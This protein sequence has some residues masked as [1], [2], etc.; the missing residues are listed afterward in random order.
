MCVAEGVLG[1]AGDRKPTMTDERDISEQEYSRRTA[2]KM[3]GTTGAL[4]LG[5]AVASG[6][7]AAKNHKGKPSEF[8]PEDVTG[9]IVG[10]APEP[11]FRIDNY[12]GTAA[13]VMLETNGP[14]DGA[15]Y[16]VGANQASYDPPEGK[17]VPVACGETITGHLT[18][19]PQDDTWMESGFTGTSTAPAC[20]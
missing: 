3:G 16:T 20:P 18:K 10:D 15:V 9:T 7:A 17:Y 13:K 4:I 2:L 8:D 14:N 6:N 11:T 19:R 1:V 5:G 12:N